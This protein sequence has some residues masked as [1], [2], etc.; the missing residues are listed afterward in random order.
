M[1]GK[2]TIHKSLLISNRSTSTLVT[3]RIF[4]HVFNCLIIFSTLL[5]LKKLGV[6]II[7][8][9]MDTVENYCPWK[10]RLPAIWLNCSLNC[11]SWRKT[12]SKETQLWELENT[13]SSA[14]VIL[15]ISAVDLRKAVIVY[16]SYQL[17]CLFFPSLPTIDEFASYLSACSQIPHWLPASYVHSFLP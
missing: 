15:A 5:R 10:L 14:E 2:P 4:P 13:I 7:V 1:F 11:P 16:V 12:R 6:L 3:A 17:T 8:N 9:V